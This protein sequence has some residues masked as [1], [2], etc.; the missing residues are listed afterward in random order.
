MD[1]SKVKFVTWMLEDKKWVVGKN[2]YCIPFG[3][4]QTMKD[5]L[6]SDLRALKDEYPTSVSYDY[7]DQVEKNLENI[8]SL[9]KM[10]RY[11]FYMHKKGRNYVP[12]KQ[13]VYN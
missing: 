8:Y 11:I 9:N 6:M 7:I 12:G 2:G 5:K 3:D 13:V 4:L 1:L 10:A